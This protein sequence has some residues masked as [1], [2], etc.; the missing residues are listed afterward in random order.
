MGDLAALGVEDLAGEIL[1]FADN[2][3][4]GGA[5]HRLPAFFRDVDQSAPHDFEADRI[6]FE[7]RHRL[8]QGIVA[9]DDD[10]TGG[11]RRQRQ[12]QIELSVHNQLGARRHQR[13]R[14]RFFDDG[15][16]G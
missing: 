7:A 10:G 1:G 11:L 3:R 14:L 13:R 8:I 12:A 9:G 16:A 2:Q 15:R 4:E 5:D 6:G